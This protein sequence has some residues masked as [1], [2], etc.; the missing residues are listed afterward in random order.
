[1]DKKDVKRVYVGNL[2]KM[3]E[4]YPNLEITHISQG[5][6]TI[7]MQNEYVPRFIKELKEALNIEEDLT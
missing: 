2:K 5:K 6:N 7:W 3:I 1:M 4:I